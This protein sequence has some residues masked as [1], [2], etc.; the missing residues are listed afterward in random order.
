MSDSPPDTIT[1]PRATAEL[2]QKAAGL[3]DKMLGDPS[4]APEAEALISKVN[5]QAVFPAR[6]SREALLAPVNA[7]VEKV[8]TEIT[9]QL[10]AAEERA[11]KLQ[12]RLDARDA[13]EAEQ[14]AK[15]QETALETQLKSIQSRRGF[16]DETM[17]AVL[18]R[19]REQNNPDVDAAAA[20]VAETIPKP[21]PASG[22]DYL[23]SQ[24]NVYGGIT[25]QENK[26]WD[27]LRENPTGWQT[28]ELRN[29][30]RDPEFLR[31]GNQ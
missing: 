8:R 26:A 30:V 2:W 28:Q 23:P 20:W 29:I 6:A 13:R 19:M 17:Q 21:L 16:S 5:P 10:T 15:A 12:E 24:V 3:V 18:T 1:V 22:H 27:G 7:A 25:D 9:G 14:A 11:A 31:L 4:T